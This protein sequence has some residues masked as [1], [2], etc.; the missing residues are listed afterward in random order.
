M[1][2]KIEAHIKSLGIT[3]PQ[4]TVPVANYVPY[5]KSGNLL[6]V[7]GQLPMRDGAVA[8]TGLVG[9]D[10]SVEQAYEGA[11]QCA[12]NLIA[13]AKAACGGDLDRVRRVVKLTGFVACA[14]PFG[15]QA[16]VMNGAS[17][18]MVSVFGDAGRH[19]RAA[20]GSSTLP[21]G[22]AVEVE[23]IFEVE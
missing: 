5:V 23:A 10:I 1:S 2:G 11:K 13:Q 14:P 4:A 6:F 16:K 18:L 7:A 8:C 21:R 19:A 3:L 22:A 12:L 15:E 9:T 20:V 17:D